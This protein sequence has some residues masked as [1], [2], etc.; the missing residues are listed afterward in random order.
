MR[1]TT[2]T[3]RIIES[4]G[5]RLQEGEWEAD[6]ALPSVA[7]LSEEYQVSPGT[8]AL[9]LKSLEH[10]GLLRVLPRIGVLATGQGV[11]VDHEGSPAIG[12]Y[13]GYST[14]STEG[15]MGRL[16]QAILNT[17]HAAGSVVQMLP[18]LENGTLTAGYCRNKGIRGLIVLGGYYTEQMASLREEGFPVITANQPL[19]VS[20][21][22]FYSYDFGAAMRDVVKKFAELGHRRIGVL[23]HETSTKQLIEAFKPEF[24]QQMF[25]EG[26]VYNLND[27][28]CNVG[29]VDEPCFKERTVAALEKLLSGPERPTAL[30]CRTRVVDILLEWLDKNQISI[31]EQLSIVGLAY[32][33]DDVL[34]SGFLLRHD[35]LGR[36]LVTS[37]YEIIR[38]PFH[39]VQRFLPLIYSDRKTTAPPLSALLRGG[40]DLISAT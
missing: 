39:S 33:E 11:G 40:N 3:S 17:A 32:E 31:P 7:A 36:H 1:K 14:S 26:L 4:L 20:P 6:A 21:L 37:L 35:E 25:D 23:S 2:K 24:L 9:A 38:N 13:G 34:T 27:Y 30:L 12:L 28:W 22:N 5:Q 16:T 19:G 8:V 15:Y 18:R 10:Q 29:E